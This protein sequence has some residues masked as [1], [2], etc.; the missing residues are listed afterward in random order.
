MEPTFLFIPCSRECSCILIKLRDIWSW[1]NCKN[2]IWTGTWLSSSESNKR[3]V[4]IHICLK[5]AG[6]MGWSCALTWVW[7]GT[8]D[9]FHAWWWT[10]GNLLRQNNNVDISCLWGKQTLF[11]RIKKG[12]LIIPLEKDR[13]RIIAALECRS[14]EWYLRIEPVRP[15]SWNKIRPAGISWDDALGGNTPTSTTMTKVIARERLLGCKQC[16]L[17]GEIYIPHDE[18]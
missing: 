5:M 10:F 9:L 16:F 13:V 6:I 15:V 8:F 17:T 18:I 2:F 7:S 14:M 4:W 11:M 12:Q 3:D 1:W